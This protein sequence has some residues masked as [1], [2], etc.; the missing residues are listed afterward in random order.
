MPT[1]AEILQERDAKIVKKF[2]Y[3]LINDDTDALAILTEIYKLGKLG[4]VEEDAESPDALNIQKELF[5]IA[6]RFY[7]YAY[8]NENSLTNG[9]NNDP[10]PGGARRTRKRRA[11][12]TRK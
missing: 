11:R 9:M 12:N 6:R 7:E 10:T 5:D 8:F 1:F 3:K 2:C 4:Y